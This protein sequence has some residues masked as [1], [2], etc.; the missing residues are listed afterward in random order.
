MD[1]HMSITKKIDSYNSLA[2]MAYV[3]QTKYF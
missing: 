3:L 2:P 1:Y